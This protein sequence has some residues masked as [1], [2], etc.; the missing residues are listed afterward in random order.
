[1]GKL[2]EKLQQVTQGGGSV[3]FVGLSRAQTQTRA[4]RPA[5]L[6]ASVGTPNAAEAALN[7][8]A[9]GVIL[10]GWKPGMNL[11]E[12][13][14]ASAGSGA[15]WGIDPAMETRP[16]G[17]LKQAKDAG[18]SFA[19]VRSSCSAHMLFEEVEG[20]DLVVSVDLPKDDLSLLLLRAENLL[21]AQ[22]ALVQAQLSPSALAK[23]TVADFA[24]LRLACE[25]LR[26]PTLLTLSGAPDVAHVK[27]LVRLGISG[28]IL[29][30]EG[31]ATDKL[32]SQ[33]KALHDQLERIP[34]RQEDRS[35]VAIGG[36]MESA[37]AS[38]APERPP[39]REPEPEPEPDEE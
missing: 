31:V 36:L 16:E 37:G 7:N 2:I 29:S 21:P 8:G 12:R 33:L 34:I 15:I 5:A 13:Q 17:L 26:F 39:R 20:F 3:G 27:T 28:L 25:S 14:S 22:V 1:M 4:P 19:I 9:D 35:S 30:G 11:G 6:L 18:A 10:A 32:G 38:L 24:R 23:M